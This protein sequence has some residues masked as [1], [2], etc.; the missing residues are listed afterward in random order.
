MK[1]RDPNRRQFMGRGLAGLTAGLIAGPH[2]HLLPRL[3]AAPPR[4]G[5]RRK[6]LVVVYLRGG[7][8]TLNVIV[9]WG[10]PE[11][12]AFRPTIGIPA[13]D[14]GDAE[15]V[16]KVNELL[17]LSP[18]L[19]PLWKH[20][21][22]GTF[23]PIVC[24]GSPHPTR[25]H[26]DAQDF[27]EY[28]APGLRTVKTGWLNRYL[29]ASRT[30]EDAPLRSIAFQ[31][32][33][34]RSLRGAYPALA[35][36]PGSWEDSKDVTDEFSELYGAGSH[37]GSE[38]MMGGRAEDIIA[39]G[40]ETI[41]TLEKLRG[42]LEDGAPREGVVYPKSSLARS[43]KS[44]AQVI[45]A[46]AGMEVTALDLGGWDTHTN[47]GSSDG[48]MARRLEG[49][50][51]ALAAFAD[52]LGKDA[53]KDTLVMVMSEFGRTCRENGNRG[54]DHG[55]GSFMFLL[56]GGVRGGQIHGTWKGLSEKH[57]YQGRDL[58]AT[59]D[60]RDVFGQVLTHHMGFELPKGFF[61]EWKPAK[62]QLQLFR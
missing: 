50:A 30:Q 27:M 16:L 47:E 2:R 21:T 32:L 29:Q 24:T 45:R 33:L 53:M 6:C 43:L 35:A 38:G 23:A 40:R 11:Y 8:D 60:F 19:K 51:A 28:A 37:S 18:A 39:V 31:R 7:A 56:G 10:E 41:E 20:F 49:V 62:R 61:P 48:S 4:A 13:T 15:G 26:F 25:S 22:T 14:E 1:T 59:T 55:H 34:P 58:P 3:F 54:T 52:D 57:L 17:G 42:V 9:P 5:R 44:V 36:P 12:R 46:D